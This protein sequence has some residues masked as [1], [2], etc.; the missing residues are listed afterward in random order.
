MLPSGMTRNI[1]LF[2]YVLP[3]AATGVWPFD[4]A[5]ILGRL[6]Q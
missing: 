6:L 5:A 4:D 2:W 1:M 3:R